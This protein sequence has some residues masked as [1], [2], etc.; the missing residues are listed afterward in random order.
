VGISTI[1]VMV[2]YLSG[3]SSSKIEIG[4]GI[5]VVNVS[6]SATPNNVLQVVSY[7]SSLLTAAFGYRYQP[8]DG[9]IIFSADMTPFYFLEKEIINKFH[10]PAGISVG[11]AF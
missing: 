1:P 4:L 8:K 2:N 6:P 5:L 9:G 10:L 11:I 3:E 7:S